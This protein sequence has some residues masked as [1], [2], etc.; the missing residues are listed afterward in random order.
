MCPYEAHRTQCSKSW[1][2][3][4]LR[5]IRVKLR[6]TANTLERIK[7]RREHLR[8]TRNFKA[9]IAGLNC[10]KKRQRNIDEFECN[11][12]T[13]CDKRLWG[14]SFQYECRM[15][16]SGH[17]TQ[18]Q[19]AAEIS[20]LEALSASEDQAPHAL[21][22]DHLLEAKSA[23]TGGGASGGGSLIVAEHLRCLPMHFFFWLY[24]IFLARFWGKTIRPDSWLLIG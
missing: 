8:M 12:N 5:K 6:E 13:S 21:Q 11:G 2:P 16:Y 18:E 3:E 23:L 10:K 22:I 9:R 17:M 7:L 1:N 4:S 24:H 15:K 19:I 20:N 14:E